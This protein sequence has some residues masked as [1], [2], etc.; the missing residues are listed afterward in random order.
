MTNHNEVSETAKDGAYSLH[1]STLMRHV[2]LAMVLAMTTAASLGS[3]V[4]VSSASAAQSTAARPAPACF[5]FWLHSGHRDRVR[6]YHC[7]STNSPYSNRVHICGNSG[8][9]HGINVVDLGAGRWATGWHRL[10]EAAR[11]AVD[12]RPSQGDGQWGAA[13]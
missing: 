7:H 5:E 10:T 11:D 1:T 2:R 13:G 8:I 3:V 9:L 4:G 12:P 6:W